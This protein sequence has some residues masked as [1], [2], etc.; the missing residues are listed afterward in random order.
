MLNRAYNVTK[1]E[2]PLSAFDRLD[3][4]KLF[5][6]D[7]GLLKHMAGIANSAILLK[8]DYQFKGPLTENCVLQQLGGQFE[9][10]P[11]YCADKTNKVFRSALI[12]QTKRFSK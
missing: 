6:F 5:V 7:T 10:E 4:F 12:T 2:H 3:C 1:T 8:T 9:I 11:R